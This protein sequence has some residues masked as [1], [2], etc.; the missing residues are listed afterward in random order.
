MTNI[1]LRYDFKSYAIKYI[2]LPIALFPRTNSLLIVNYCPGLANT[3][4]STQQRDQ[5]QLKGSQLTQLIGLISI[6][7]NFNS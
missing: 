3:I 4:P 1:M 7:I 5:Y 6:F 2:L